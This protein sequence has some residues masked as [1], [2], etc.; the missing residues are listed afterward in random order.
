MPDVINFLGRQCNQFAYYDGF[1]SGI[2]KRR[3]AQEQP[4][5][6]SKQISI[7]PGG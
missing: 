5:P 3:A 1:A 7:H 6:T 4:I 2:D